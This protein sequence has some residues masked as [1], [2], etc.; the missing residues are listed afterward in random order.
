MKKLS[1]LVPR[2]KE[3]QA[4]VHWLLDS[5]AMQQGVNLD[6]V[7]VIIVNDGNEDLL[8]KDWL[9][10]YPLDIRYEP[11]KKCGVS[12]VRNH[13]LSLAK[14][15]Y[16]MWCD[17]D[18][19][20]INLFGLHVIFENMAHGY[21]VIY[22]VFV[23]ECQK[24]TGGF[25]LVKHENDATFVHGKA[26]RRQFLIDNKLRFAPELTIHED[27]FFNCLAQTVT[28][29]K[30]YIETPFYL[31]KW[32]SNSVVRKDTEMFT[33]RTY[34]HLV[35]ARAKLLDEL[36]ARGLEEKYKNALAKSITDFYYDFQKPQY[37]KADAELIRQAE[38]SVGRF[39]RVHKEELREIEKQRIAEFMYLSRV[40]AFRE[41]AFYESM[42]LPDWLRHIEEIK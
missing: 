17:A 35:K 28:D 4:I 42:T 18:D 29:N 3:P 13:A 9:A 34:R 22:S 12:A 36:K 41:E 5:I 11:I 31:W 15:D 38:K 40:N 23:E 16:V 8:D 37:R 33:L 10:K 26:Y 27:G 6:E 24:D 32:N 30:K 1:V 2:Y 7:E 14:G 19:M 39:Y 25:G 21:D 20:F